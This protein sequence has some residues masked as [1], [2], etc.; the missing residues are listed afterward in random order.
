M[1]LAMHE[2][3]LSL[4]STLAPIGAGTFIMLAVS[5]FA[6]KFDEAQLKRIDRLTIIPILVVL[7]GLGLSFMHLANP[8]NAMAVANT[9]F[10]SPLAN[11]ITAVGVFMGVAVIYW[12]VAVA[13]GLK[14]GSVR[15]GFCLVVGVLGVIASVFIGCAYLLPTIPSWNTFWSPVTL[16]GIC[17][18]GGVLM[19]MMICSLAGA[20]D[21]AVGGSAESGYTGLLVLGFLCTIVGVVAL[22]IIGNSTFSAVL[23]VPALAG[24]LIWAFVLFLILTVLAF[25]MALFQIKL[26]PFTAITVIAVVLFVVAVW[27]SRLCFYGLQ[28]GMGL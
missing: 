1:E 5:F 9:M 11:E 13:G 3:P 17:L 2:I 26:M 24:S 12:I 10:S 20:G 25:V 23:D 8:A 28:I 22:W 27:F 4:F 18:M 15:W 6:G 19:A 14:N 16:F 7:L 21:E